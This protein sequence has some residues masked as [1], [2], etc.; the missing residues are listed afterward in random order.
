MPKWSTTGAAQ[1]VKLVLVPLFGLAMFYLEEQRD[2]PR[3]L[4]LGASMILIGILPAS[5]LE[6]F[7]PGRGPDVPPTAP[8]GPIQPPTPPPALPSAGPPDGASTS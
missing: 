1:V 6:R 4:L 2:A 5:Y 8:T 7:F 3:P